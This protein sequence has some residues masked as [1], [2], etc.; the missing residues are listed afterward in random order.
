MADLQASVDPVAPL[1]SL[2]TL[3]ELVRASGP[4]DLAEA[5]SGLDAD[6]LGDADPTD[7]RGFFARVLLQ[8]AR[9]GDAACEHKPQAGLLKPLGHG[10]ALWL[11]CAHC[12]HEWEYPRTRCVSCGQ[13]DAKKLAYYQAEE[14]PHIQVM[15]CEECRQYIHLIDSEKEPGAVADI[16]EV[17]ALPLDLWAIE[18]GYSKVQPNLV[19]I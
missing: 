9:F 2:P 16:D 19:G 18:R 6:S 15:S 12:F 17:A 3:I 8:P 1:D 14:L 11:S 7:P 10:H 13:T 4:H 5:A